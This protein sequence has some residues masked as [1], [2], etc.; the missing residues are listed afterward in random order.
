[1]NKVTGIILAG[2]KSLRM[3]QDKA[4]LRFGSR[5]MIKEIFARVK[6]YTEE[7]IIIANQPEK[8]SFLKVPVFPDIIAERGPLGGIYT[9][10]VKSSTF[11]NFVVSCDMPFLNNVLINYLAKRIDG[12]DIIIANYNDRLQPLCAFYSQNC[13]E[14]IKIQLDEGNLRIRDLLK[15]VNSNIIEQNEIDQLNLDERAFL[16]INSLEDISLFKQ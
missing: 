9:G 2:G 11:Y 7:I 6:E 13:I 4:F 1:M 14:P 12:Y 16:N 10:L 5:L 3:G 15:S 8:F